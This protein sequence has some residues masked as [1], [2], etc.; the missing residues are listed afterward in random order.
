[1]NLKY[2]LR[3]ARKNREDNRLYF[4]SLVLVYI[5][6]Y[7]VLSFDKSAISGFLYEENI[8]TIQ[9]YLNQS[10]IG[11]L[12]F[13]LTLI[14]FAS[15]NQ[16]DNR[17]EDFALMMMMGE[18]RRNISRRLS[19][20]AVFNSLFALVIAFPIAIFL[21]E[22]INLFVIKVL[23]LGLKSHKLRI[24]LLAVFITSLVVILLQVI[25]IRLIS[26]FILRKE[27]YKLITGKNKD[28]S[29]KGKKINEKRSL[30][31]SVIM[32]VGAI[33]FLVVLSRVDVVSVALFF[34][35]LYFFYR[36]F[37]YILDKISEKSLDNIFEIRLIEEKFRFEYKSLFFTNVIMIIAFVRLTLPLTQSFFLRADS[38]NAP[39]FTI[40]DNKEAVENMYGQE[41]YHKTLEKPSP[42]YLSE[43]KYKDGNAVDIRLV[44]E[45]RSIDDIYGYIIKESSMDYV[46]E[47]M[48][49]EKVN[50]EP[51]EAML[52]YSAYDNYSFNKDRLG[53]LLEAST[54]TIESRTFDLIPRVEP[55][56]IFSNHQVFFSSGL[57]VR[58][59][60]Y[61]ELAAST[62]PYAYNLYIKSAYKNEEG[63]IKASEKIR[64]MMIDDGLKYESK[65]WQIKNDISDLV[66][67][68]Y[69]NLY[70]G[71]LLFII[72]NTYIAF[73]FIYWV[74]EN[75]ERFAIKKLLGEDSA[76][77]KKR[78]Q[79]IIDL[80]FAVLF[81][82]SFGANYFYYSINIASVGDRYTANKFFIYINICLVIFELIY[83]GVIKKI[84]RDQIE[85]SR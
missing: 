73:K 64:D 25:S 37:S 77:T 70:L 54:A 19:L 61:D 43:I 41:K 16:L 14:F 80:Y 6:S 85:K 33:V 67:D 32:F 63:T 3:D 57:V 51:G 81:L 50:L 82:I 21:N 44:G 42:F 2:V 56:E 53:E 71:L 74:K 75:R 52:V 62:N 9:G 27:A 31:I 47:K 29:S 55:N 72:A 11:S 48:G 23:E 40:Y 58:D 39:D 15:K 12:I 76:Q 1:M 84:T 17:K 38:N 65:V 13:L 20:E 36:G 46:L 22:F 69:T 59:K 34:I 60:T 30:Q 8:F 45:K 78:M 35:G 79:R 18:K 49:K 28:E 7:T 83:I 5:V 24:S 68:L 26:F 66:T 10:Y 4:Y